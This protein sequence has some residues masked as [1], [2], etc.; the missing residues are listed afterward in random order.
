MAGGVAEPP[1]TIS[2]LCPRGLEGDE[3]R[4]GTFL[5]TGGGVQYYDPGGAG[6]GG[7]REYSR[8][9]SRREWPRLAV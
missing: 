4:F 5:V 1:Q 9:H 2:P 8:R 6:L 7:E 3:R